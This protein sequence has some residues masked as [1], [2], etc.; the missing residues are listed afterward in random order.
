MMAKPEPESVFMPKSVVLW[1]LFSIIGTASS[2]PSPSRS[3]TSI[4][5]TGPPRFVIACWLI[6]ACVSLSMST[7]MMS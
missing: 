7:T 6:T 5:P 1:A 3:R 4:S 2:L